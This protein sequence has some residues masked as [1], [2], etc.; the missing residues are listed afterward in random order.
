MPPVRKKF[1]IYSADMVP[2]LVGMSFILAGEITTILLGSNVAMVGN[3]IRSPWGII[4]SNFI[5][6]GI[7]NIE[8]YAM[9]LFFLWVTSVAY[10]SKIRKERYIASMISMFVGAFIAN[11]IW[12]YTMYLGNNPEITG[13]QSAV[14][15]AFWGAC[16]SLFVID[17]VLVLVSSISNKLL[18]NSLRVASLASNSKI[19][20]I[21]GEISSIIFSLI[22]LVDIYDGRVAFFSE[23]PH[24]NYFIH[25]SGFFSG[26][27]IAAG[28][29]S[30]RLYTLTRN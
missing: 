18:H 1:R 27:F 28:I 7:N 6:D 16:F 30:W 15:Y 4:T 14:V 9:F 19:R 20:R 21:V 29:Y 10:Q 22:I 2:L 13:G 5:F 24:F 25:I 11:G 23:L 17:S 12:L 8:A 26:F 3:S